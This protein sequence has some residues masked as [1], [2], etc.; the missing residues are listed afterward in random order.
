MRRRTVIVNGPLAL[1]M[2]RFEAA[3]NGDG[4]LQISTLALTAARLAGGFCQ[5][6][7]TD[8]IEPAITKALE[9]GTFSELEPIRTL[10]GMTRAIART[11]QKVWLADLDL[12]QFAVGKPRINDLATI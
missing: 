11:L 7:V 12:S 2:R 3:R 6:A 5:P 4:G 10:P 1:R 8:H 9:L